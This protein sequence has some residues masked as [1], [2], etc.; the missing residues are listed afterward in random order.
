MPLGSP[1]KEEIAGMKNFGVQAKPP[2]AVTF[3]GFPL[4][5]PQF[6]HL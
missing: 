1:K 2:V 6:A 3:S 5:E 4:S